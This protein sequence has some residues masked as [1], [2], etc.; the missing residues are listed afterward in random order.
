V[1]LG[2]MLLA[3]VVGMVRWPRRLVGRT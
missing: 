1:S 3:L 2:V